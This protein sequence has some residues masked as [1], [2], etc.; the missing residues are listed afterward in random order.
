MRAMGCRRLKAIRSIVNALSASLFPVLNAFFIMG[1]V[2]C[3]VKL[4]A[5]LF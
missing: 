2:L 4:L 1:I 5:P 3:L